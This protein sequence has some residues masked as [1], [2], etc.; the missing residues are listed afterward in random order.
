[1]DNFN[2]MQP[3]Y[4]SCLIFELYEDRSIKLFFRNDTR[5]EPYQM[6]ICHEKNDKNKENPFFCTLP[7]WTFESTDLRVENVAQFHSECGSKDQPIPNQDKKL[8][9]T[10]GLLLSTWL[11]IALNMC[12]KIFY[13]KKNNSNNNYSEFGNQAHAMDETP[14]GSLNGTPLTGRSRANTGSSLFRSNQG[15]NVE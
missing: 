15:E 3:P 6:E 4:A 7:Q 10:I 5:H 9:Y 12:F 11:G 14:P 2:F 8:L 1:M 13:V